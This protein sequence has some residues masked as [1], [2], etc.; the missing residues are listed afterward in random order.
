M[1]SRAAAGQRKRMF[2]G[3]LSARGD[4]GER[5]VIEMALLY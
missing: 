2:F 4:D 1:P 3:R 5:E